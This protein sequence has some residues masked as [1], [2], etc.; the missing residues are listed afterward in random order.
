[1][2]SEAKEQ[3]RSRLDIAEVIG[4]QVALKPAGRGQLKGLCPF[5]D[6]KTPSFHVHRDKGFF[7]CFG[8]Q[9][10]GDVYDFVM[11]TQGISFAEALRHLG[12]RAGVEVT[13]PTP[14]DR[15]RS[16]AVAINGLAQ[17][18][19][20]ANLR[21]ET[22]GA[23]AREYLKARKISAASI[24]KFGI[25]FA[26][27]GWDGLLRYALNKGHSD[28]ELMAAGLLSENERGR[29]YD[30]FR[31]RLMFPIRDGLSRIVGFAGRVLDDSLPKYLN[32]PETETF[33]KSQLLYGLDLARPEIREKG[34]CIV[35]EG[36]MDVIALHQVGIRN[37]VAALGA[38]MTAD[39]ATLLSRLDV[40]RL[41]LA[42]DSDSAGQRAVLS[43]LEQAVGR[44]FLVRAV[45]VPHGKDPADA[46][47]DGDPA[48]FLA[49]LQE[50][51]SEVEFRFS[52]VLAKYD[53][54]TVQGQR[55]I[56]EELA[57]ALRPRSVFDPVASEMRRLVL[58]KLKMDAA[59]L[60]AWVRDSSPRRLNEVQVRGMQRR[61]PG[62]DLGRSALLELEI[63]AL[64]LR[65]PASLEE[66]LAALEGAVPSA[67]DSLL[68]EFRDICVEC[69][70]DDR[71]VLLRYRERDEA[72]V[73]WERLFDNS[74]SEAEELGDLDAHLEMMLSQLRELYLNVQ[75][76]QHRQK[77]LERMAQ[78]QT[79]LSDPDLPA[80]RLAELYTELKEL[81]ST[82][83]AREG[84][85][86]LR[87]AKTIQRTRRR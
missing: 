31:N 82:L 46:V 14:R 25:G 34:E 8:C 85:R 39:Q 44:Q 74:A 60:D 11:R 35:V 65:E 67:Q 37:A 54:D 4:E 73:L 1:L 79:Q 24:E 62:N 9:A 58:D 57:P 28:Q 13:P 40:Q 23:A 20:L 32:T 68:A 38:T 61:A 15:Q 53:P 5:H 7:Y 6:E 56:L 55:A 71:E 3:I 78:L 66:R 22:V 43:G 84:E 77:L 41:Y 52:N 30:R 17:E 63:I 72:R 81:S 21:D 2:S 87:A 12:E 64:L 18:Y 59:A 51:L 76:E 26:P 33:R 36:Y 45:E 42:F 29:R 86:Q 83:T 10:K 69:N 47:L 27:E 19:F 75:N 16:D 80:A 50:G 70:Y 49:V 48:D